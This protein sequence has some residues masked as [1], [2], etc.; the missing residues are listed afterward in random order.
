MCLK[1]RFFW[2]KKIKINLK[3]CYRKTIKVINKYAEYKT[4]KILTKLYEEWVKKYEFKEKMIDVKFPV[5][6]NVFAYLYTSNIST[7]N[8]LLLF[9][10]SWMHV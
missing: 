2:D 10:F 4:Y 7:D 3:F 5:V 9:R 1:L 6:K 8:K